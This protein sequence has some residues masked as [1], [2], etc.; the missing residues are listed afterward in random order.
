MCIRD[1]DDFLLELT[2]LIAE[3]AGIEPLYPAAAGVEL[4]AREN[5]RGCVVF[6][7]NNNEES[8]WVDFGDER[9][10]NLMTGEAVTGR[11]MLAPRDVIVAKINKD[12]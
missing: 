6:A 10:E 3:E 7:I 2:G 5:E 9:L 8:A 11:T 12:N 4:T 1:R